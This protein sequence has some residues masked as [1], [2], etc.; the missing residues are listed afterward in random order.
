MPWDDKVM[1]AA[2]ESERLRHATI[3]R[4]IAVE[5]VGGVED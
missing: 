1:E 4:S 2:A 5:S 3:V